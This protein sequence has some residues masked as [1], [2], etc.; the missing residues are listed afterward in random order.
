NKADLEEQSLDNFFNNLKICEAEVKVTAASISAP[1]ISTASSKAKSNSPQL[2]NED[3]KQIDPDDLEEM[4]LKWQMAML[5]MRAR[6]FLKRTRRN[7]G[8]NGTY[9]IGFD[10]YNVKCY[11]YHKR[12]HFAKECRSPQDNRNKETTRRT[13]PVEVSTSN[14]LVSQCS[15]SSLGLGN[16]NSERNNLKLTLDK[17]QTS[18]K[19]LSKLLESQTGKGYHDVPSP[20]TGTFLLP[21]PDLVF[22][23]DANAKLHSHES[24]NTVPKNLEND[25]YRQISDSKDETK[26]ESMPKQGEP[27]FVKSSKHVKTS[28]ETVKKVEHL[29]QDYDYY[30]KQMVQ[31]PMWNNAMRMNHQNLV[32]MTHPYSNRNVV[33]T[34]V[35]T[36]SRLVS[37]NAARPVPT[38]ITQSNTECVVLSSD[39]KLH[40]EN[41]V[42]LRVPREN[43]MYNVDLKNVVPS[44]GIK[45]NLDAGK[46]GKETVSAQQ[47]VLLPLWSTGLPDPQ[48]TNDDV[49]DAAFDAKRDDKGKSPVDS[50]T[51][52][53][54]LRAEF[55]EIFLTVLT[56]LLLKSSFVDPS[57]YPDDPDMPELEDIVYSDDEED[58]GVEAD[59]SNLETNIHASPIPTTRFHK[60]HHVNQI[61][62]TECVVLSFDFKLHDE[63]H[64]L[65]R[66][67]RENN[68][69]N[70]DLK[71]GVPSGEIKREFNVVTTPQQNGI[72]ER[73]NKTLIE[74][75]KTMLADSLLP[76]PF[77]AKAVNTACYVQNRVLVT[78]PHNKTPYELL[79]GRSPS[80]GFMRPF[81]CPVTILNTLHPLGKFDGKANEGILDRYSNDVHVSA[82]GS[83]KSANK[84]HDE[85]AKRDDKGNNM[86]ELEDIVYSDDEED[87]G[88]EADLSNLETNIHVSPI[89][90]TRFHKDHHVNQIIDVKSA[91]TS[92]ETEKP[93][94]KDPDGEDVD[95]H[96]YR[97]LKGKPHLGLWYPKDSPFNL[98]AYSDSD[99][100]RASLNRKSTT[101]GYQFLGC[102][103]IS[104]QCKKQTVVATSSTKAE[105][106]AAAS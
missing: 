57:K 105:Y 80:I 76:I 26:I 52:V 44:R 2:D 84:K 11:N 43:N 8:A 78:K 61:I 103:L 19:N 85:K 48:N 36:R 42:L 81:G 15:S 86:P 67:P 24:D 70:V 68:M 73:K 10:M 14:A 51:G 23:N 22:T 46:V 74:A 102:R 91:S 66:V 50:P 79:L 71:N 34:T 63:N 32:R 40:D 13:V 18:S 45:E 47:Y 83:N 69:Y 54:D 17:F 82:N 90:T 89:P 3:L 5:T 75:A 72:A 12:G 62:D 4:N 101:E 99:Y 41:H 28:R 88:V 96:I 53:R 104:W 21:E 106:I 56:G 29:K 64:V 38:A 1:S 20:Y 97:Y 65:L 58:V 95:V 55:E 37:L 25:R 59:L 6:R 30:E 16:E 9:T 94:L 35:L 93:L 49:A 60:D 31:E 33:P 92:I 98:V 7:L 39:F 27:S 77:W 100:A 87:V